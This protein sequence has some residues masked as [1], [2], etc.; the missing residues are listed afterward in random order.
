MT[1]FCP[2]PDPS[3]GIAL[4]LTQY[5]GCEARVLGENGFLAL[6]AGPLGAGLLTAL[7]TI[8]IALIGYRMVL[9]DTPSVRD[10][11]GWFMRLGIVLALVTSWPAFQV[12]IYRVAVDGPVEIASVLL[13][14]S[15]LP[16][17]DLSGRV[18]HVYDTLRLGTVDVAAPPSPPGAT[19]APPSAQQFKF[20]SPLPNTASLLVISTLGVVAA[21]EI[22]LGFLLAAAPLPLMSLLFRGTSGLFNGWLRAI[23]GAALTLVAATIVTAIDL[24]MVES[25]LGRL[26]TLRFTASSGIV[27]PQALTTI[28]ALFAMV[29]LVL[30]LM[31]LK[32]ASALKL[33]EALATPILA[34]RESPFAF[35]RIGVTEPSANRELLERTSERG[36]QTRVSTVAEVLT[37]TMHRER[38]PAPSSSEP[39]SRSWRTSE[40][41][42]RPARRTAPGRLGQI[43]RRGIVRRTRSAIRRDK[44][45]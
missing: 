41:V 7:V 27:D 19:Q 25:E 13:P 34:W 6:G 43:G 17:A 21:L 30:V 31:S 4:R 28:V 29:M 42:E 15:G 5:V 1:P 3:L 14:A 9:G 12:L 24:V 40:A 32:M 20:Q 11:V 45:S 33:P 37:R 26:E 18:Q 8:F 38:S 35:G 36:A 16:A 44:Q 2:A 39:P 22:A 10:G 23:A